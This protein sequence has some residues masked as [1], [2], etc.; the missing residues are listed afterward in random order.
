MQCYLV[1]LQTPSTISYPGHQCQLVRAG[2]GCCAVLG[3]SLVPLS[4]KAAG[5]RGVHVVSWQKVKGSCLK[6]PVLS[7]TFSIPLW[8][9]GKHFCVQCSSALLGCLVGM[10]CKGTRALSAI[11][12]AM[13]R[14]GGD[15]FKWFWIFGIFFFLYHECFS[16][17][18]PLCF[19]T[20]IS[21]Y[22]ECGGCKHLI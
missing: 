11:L 20:Q 19:N 22:S 9:F 15:P 6:P 13:I 1:Q 16:K 17:M 2:Q 21:K 5:V 4:I 12:V 8:V 18:Q 14:T 10:M 7:S 3:L